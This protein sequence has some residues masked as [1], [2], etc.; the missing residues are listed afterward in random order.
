MR[1]EKKL[2][3][4]IF[5]ALHTTRKKAVHLCRTTVPTNV[6]MT[7]PR[8]GE[9]KVRRQRATVNPEQTR[10]RAKMN[11]IPWGLRTTHVSPSGRRNA[12]GP[13][14]PPLPPLPGRRDSFRSDPI[15]TCQAIAAR[16]CRE[17]EMPWICQAPSTKHVANVGPLGS[18]LCEVVVRA[19]QYYS[20]AVCVHSSK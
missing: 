18:P 10:G 1:R 7:M 11:F 9:G 15:L 2:L 5:R 4:P 13:D 14:I 12:P 20:S 16:V 17:A 3:S 19:R 6:H 8:K